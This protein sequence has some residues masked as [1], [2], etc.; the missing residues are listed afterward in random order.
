MI[1]RVVEEIAF[2][3]FPHHLFEKEFR[4]FFWMKKTKV[5]DVAGGR[6]NQK[7]GIHQFWFPCTK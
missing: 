3:Q 7:E 2:L 5:A 4:L 6:K 1:P